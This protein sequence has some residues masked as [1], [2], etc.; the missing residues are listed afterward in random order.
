MT[1]K[2][3]IVWPAHAKIVFR[4]KHAR[5]LKITESTNLKEQLWTGFEVTEKESIKGENAS[6]YV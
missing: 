1:V 4:S 3:R 5:H 6:Y 2:I